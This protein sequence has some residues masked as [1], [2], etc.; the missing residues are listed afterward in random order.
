MLIGPAGSPA[1]SVNP[2]R[3]PFGTAV[4]EQVSSGSGPLQ[5]WSTV[6]LPGA[7]STSRC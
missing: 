5:P 2:T 3:V 6:S 4:A 7:S 1:S